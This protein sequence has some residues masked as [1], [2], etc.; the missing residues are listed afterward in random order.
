MKKVP[1]IFLVTYHWITVYMGQF[2]ELSLVTSSMIETDFFAPLSS[3][4]P[5]IVISTPTVTTD[6]W[7]RSPIGWKRSVNQAAKPSQ[8][9]YLFAYRL[10]FSSHFSFLS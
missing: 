5:G 1:I 9:L 6:R 7:I 10:S 3:W 8:T 2:G 4:L